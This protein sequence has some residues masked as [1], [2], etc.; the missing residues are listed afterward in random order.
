MKSPC[1]DCTERHSGCHGK[2]ELY[3]AYRDDIENRKKPELYAK[4]DYDGYV[5]EVKLK[6]AL[7]RVPNNKRN[8]KKER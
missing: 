1:K 3:R 5:R 6:I 7:H 8:W 2:C 4:C